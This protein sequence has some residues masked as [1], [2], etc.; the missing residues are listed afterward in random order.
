MKKGSL[1]VLSGPS[2]SG[3]G[4]VVGEL[5]K[6]SD[7]CVSVSATTRSPRDGEKEG[8]NYFFKTKEEFIALIDNNE[9]IEY[10]EYLGNFYG[11][12]SKFVEDKCN[13]GK[14][15][16]L[17]IEVV[18]AKNIKDKCPDATMIF[19]LPP[20]MSVLKERLQG[21]GTESPEQIKNRLERA[22]EELTYIGNYEHFVV[23]DDLNTTVNTIFNII[24]GE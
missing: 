22:K 4:T 10:A 15:V 23:N 2:G 17:E 6:N 19:L 13:E 21:R 1:I 7:F 11:T 12:P 18:G 24:K 3:K 5:V 14:N 20:S 8:V 16:I 9:L